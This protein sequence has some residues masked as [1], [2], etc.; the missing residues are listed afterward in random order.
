M[1]NLKLDFIVFFLQIL[2]I[3]WTEVQ[4]HINIFGVIY[5]DSKFARAI[6]DKNNT[7]ISPSAVYH[8]C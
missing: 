1:D 8:K 6:S 7:V 4:Q 3:Y 5:T 2:Y